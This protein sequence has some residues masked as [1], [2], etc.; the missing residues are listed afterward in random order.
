MSDQ[1]ETIVNHI[2]SDTQQAVVSADS[3][4]SAGLRFKSIA[5]LYLTLPQ[6]RAASIVSIK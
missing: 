3:P 2:S 5:R 1:S 4:D 6:N